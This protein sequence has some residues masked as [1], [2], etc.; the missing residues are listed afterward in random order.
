MYTAPLPHRF[1]IVSAQ[2]RT[3][4]TNIDTNRDES[5]TD[6][7]IL[8]HAQSIGRPTKTSLRPI[9]FPAR[10]APGLCPDEQ[11]R[12][13]DT[14]PRPRPAVPELHDANPPASGP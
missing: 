7:N 6:R 3:E 8:Q 1:S 4:N 13:A 14:I 2:H 10:P 5:R 12:I 9:N 11:S